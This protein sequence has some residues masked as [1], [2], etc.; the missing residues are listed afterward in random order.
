MLS[1]VVAIP[2]LDHGVTLYVSKYISN[3]SRRS[4]CDWIGI[5][6]PRTVPV[7]FAESQNFSKQLV[8]NIIR[9]I[10]MNLDRSRDI[11]TRVCSIEVN[12]ALRV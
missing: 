2:R 11:E 5:Y 7:H 4:D 3:V 12:T 1:H 8:G 6:K 9:G 10:E